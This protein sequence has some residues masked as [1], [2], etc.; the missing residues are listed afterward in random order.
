VVLKG[1]VHPASALAC[2]CCRLV[3]PRDGDVD[4]EA[5]IGADDVLGV[6]AE[7]R[8]R[9]LLSAVGDDG[10]DRDCEDR[11]GAGDT[12]DRSPAAPALASAPEFAY[13][14]WCGRRGPVQDTIAGSYRE[15]I[16]SHETTPC[17]LRYLGRG[18]LLGGR[19]AGAL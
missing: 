19:C 16:E 9:R 17:Q 12:G 5:Q 4:S 3:G 2:A 8:W 14:W 6:G 7:R 10:G 18:R 13:V 11:D 1:A 15:L